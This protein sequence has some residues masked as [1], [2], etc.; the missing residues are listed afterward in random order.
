VTT[1]DAPPVAATRDY[2]LTGP[3]SERARAAGL[4]DA[5][6]YLPPIDADRL[7][8]LMV[9]TNGRA[10]RDVVIWIGLLVTAGVLAF[11]S[12]GTWWAIPAFVA[13]GA[14]YGGAADPRWHECGHGTAFRS[15]WANDLIYPVASFMLLREPT[16]WRW[17]HVRH[18]SDT[19]IV[20][21]DPEITF[22]R[23]FRVPTMLPNLFQL[24]NGPKMLWGMVRHSTGRIEDDIRVFVPH[25]ELRRIV[26]EARVF[27]AIFL[28]VIVW[29]ISAWT[30]VPL[31]F[32]GL[33]SFYGVWLLWFFATT[34][35]AGLRED[36]LDHRLN[37]R[38]VHMNPIFRFLYLNMN[39][40]VEHHLFPTVPYH[41][42]PAL[43]REVAEYLPP[44]KPNVRSAYREIV[45][46]L[47]EQR[48]DLRW[49]IPNLGVPESAAASATVE[50][51]SPL[52]PAAGVG[53]T[54]TV[55]GSV[56]LVQPGQ[57]KRLDLHR[58]TYVLCRLPDGTYSLV[59]GLCT[60]AQTHLGDGLLI[61][62]C[63]ECP[64]HNGRFDVLT[65]E[66]V[67]KPVKIPLGTYQV[68]VV[69][70]QLVADLT[71]PRLR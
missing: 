32:I 25:D 36:V 44:A 5:A 63:I 47:R 56:D 71:A 60:H 18:H 26:W 24:I 10:A 39:Y 13:Y 52:A 19:I 55:L 27:V 35:H 48:R 9:R 46:A 7:Q 12:L 58:G 6:W 69:D 59:D 43:H 2:S 70:G 67:R 54:A 16:V 1:I 42:L 15:R 17:S 8:Q 20:G 30:I 61:D 14:L 29:S 4:E 66:P 57:L 23:P 45:H 51:R 53:A 41:A 64:K 34:Q 50:P 65:G 22:Q 28:G 68:E 62:G 33:P 3:E 38:T 37:T 31:L 49:E 40:H 11:I 21:L